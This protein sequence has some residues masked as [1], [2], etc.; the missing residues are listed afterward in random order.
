MNRTLLTTAAL[1]ITA[2]SHADG[3]WKAYPAY[4]NVTE[5][6][7]AGGNLLYILASNGLYSYNRSDQSLQTYDKTTVLSDCGI[8]HIGWNQAARR[9]VIVYENQNIDLLEANSN[10]I[11]I[12]DYYAKSMTEDKTIN[13]L[14]MWRGYAYLSTGFGIVKLNVAEGEISDTYNLGFNVAYSYLQGDSIYAASPTDGLYAAAQADNLLDK[15]SWSRVGSYHARTKTIDADVLALVNTL[16]P[17]GPKHNTFGYM[18]FHNGRLFTCCGGYTAVDDLRRAGCVQVLSGDTWQV[19]QDDFGTREHRYEDVMS[20]AVNPNSVSHV[21]AGSR[22]GLYEFN[23]GQLT[24]QYSFDNSPLLPA[25]TGN[26]NYVIVEA[27]AYDR[28]GTLWVI[29]SNNLSQSILSFDGSQWTG[30]HHAELM[31]NGITHRHI[32][33]LMEDSR[34]LLW[35]VNNDFRFP[36]LFG[37]QPSTD[38]LN[39]YSTFTNEDGTTVAV[40]Y[41]RCVA[42]D[43]SRNIWFGTNV[44]PLMLEEDQITA[45]SPVFTQPKV[46]RN[47]GTDLADYLLSGVDI[48]SIY[49]DQANRK[50]FGTNGSGV[51][52]IAADNV[53]QIAHFTAENSPLLSDYIESMAM[54]PTTGEM[55]FGTDRGLCS[56]QSDA[57]TAGDEMTKDNVWAYPNPVKPGYTGAVTITGLQDGCDVKIVTSNGVLVNEGKASGTTYKWYCQDRKAQRVASGIYFVQVATAEGEKGTVCKVAVVN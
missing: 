8:A 4:S 46:P 28:E 26:K 22:G 37:Y 1:L 42:E 27:V 44:G 40:T 11:N 47:D 41:A 33:G 35:F 24:E 3:L 9:L 54:N 53:S 19:Y 55:F 25:I 56:Y 2:L 34:G 45:T 20:V 52:L 48:S 14:F 10:V 15:S 39:T 7:E 5:V 13:D 51:Y 17:G 38:G 29:N 12:N 57:T 50:W 49:V 18:M 36:A 43:R 32:Q 16:A 31:Q 30:H 6:E 23:N 21:F